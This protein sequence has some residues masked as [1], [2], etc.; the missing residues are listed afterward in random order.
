M[1]RYINISVLVDIWYIDYYFFI[2]INNQVG[3]ILSTERKCIIFRNLFL[4]KWS[5]NA[6]F[7]LKDFWYIFFLK[8]WEIRYWI[9]V[10]GSDALLTLKFLQAMLMY[11][12]FHHNKETE[13]MFLHFVFFL[14]RFSQFV[15]Y[16]K[17]QPCDL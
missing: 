8:Q 1:C 5:T 11:W 15:S 6:D 3:Y 14:Y 7:L 17:S 2:Y 12:F 9:S 13:Q 4:I 10:R 16:S